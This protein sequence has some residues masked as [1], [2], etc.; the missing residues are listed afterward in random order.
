MRPVEQVR[1]F[2]PV[3]RG[4]GAERVRTAAAPDPCG[5]SADVGQAAQGRAL[6]PLN[7]SREAAP[8]TPRPVERARAPF[9]AHLIATHQRLPQTRER[10]RAKP[11]EAVAAYAAAVRTDERQAPSSTWIARV[12]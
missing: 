8:P 1:A 9:V 10:R 11:A 3:G 7:G 6:V 2:G 12:A 4:R 5:P